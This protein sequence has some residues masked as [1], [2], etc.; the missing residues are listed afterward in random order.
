MRR[1]SVL[2]ISLIAVLAGG[3]A[4]V[5]ADEAKTPLSAAM[6]L[7]IVA[8]PVD[9]LGYR[10]WLDRTREELRRIGGRTASRFELTPTEE[11]VASLVAEGKTNKEVAAE[12]MVSVRAVE[13]N[14]SRIYQKLQVRSRAELARSYRSS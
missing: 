8:A 5:A 2:L 1:T 11:R 12:L 3:A 4:T 6:I 7:S 13:A 14:L 10:L 9:E